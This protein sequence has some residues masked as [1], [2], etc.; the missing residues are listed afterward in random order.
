MCKKVVCFLLI[1]LMSFSLLMAETEVFIRVNQVGYKL[2][3]NKVAIAFS[4]EAADNHKFEIIKS[5]TMERVWGPQEIKEDLGPWAN[6]DHYYRLDFSGFQ[7]PGRYKIKITGQDWNS[8][9]FQ[10]GDDSYNEYNE[11]I[12]GYIQQQRCGY[13]PFFDEVCHPRDGRTMYGPMPD[14]TFIDVTGGWHDAGDHLQYLLTSGNSVCRMLFSYRENKG[15]FQ[16]KVDKFGHQVKNGIPDVL[17]EAKWGLD[18]MLKMHPKP[19]QLFHQIADDRDHIGFKVPF[20]DSADYG[21]GKGSYR[22]LYYAN[23]KPQGLKKYQNT[24]DG[25]ANLA[26]RYAAAMAMAHDIWKNDLGDES[27]ANICLK[28]GQEVYQMGLEKPGCQEGTPC[29]APYRYYESSWADDMEWGAAELYKVTGDEKYLNQA[30][31]FAKLINT[32]SWMGA[33]TARHYEYYPFMNIGHYALYQV[34]DEDFQELLAD[35]YKTN[36]KAVQERAQNNPFNIGIPFIWCSNNL[37]AAFVTQCILYEKMTGD[38][39]FRELMQAHRAWLLGRNPWGV[40][41]F[42]GI[43]RYGRFP[44][45]PHTAVTEYTD[46][47]IIGGL[48][49]GPVY[50]S[51]YNSLKGIRLSQPDKYAKFQS[52]IVV[53]HDDIWDYSTNEPTLDGTAEALYFFSFF[54]NR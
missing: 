53:Y 12:I 37:C 14:S 19:D 24:S 38:D 51:I 50:A 31:E 20:K 27:F 2:N 3:E 25:I 15:K 32:V 49:D 16:D 42:I 26:G 39:Q 40:S 11:D 5:Q 34:A 9:P 28:A 4:S 41:Q 1:G 52:D 33:D 29:R 45:Y 47:L 8:Q 35:Y 54:D 17:D 48:N 13:N 18:W 21:W 6:F 46:R 36:I 7:E 30:K 23:G 10:I 43:P 22:V 44:H